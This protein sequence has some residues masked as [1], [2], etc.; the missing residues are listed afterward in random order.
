MP[1]HSTSMMVQES[2][3]FTC[4]FLKVGHAYRHTTFVTTYRRVQSPFETRE[5]R[6]PSFVLL[7][8]G[9]ETNIHTTNSSSSSHFQYTNQTTHQSP[10]LLSRNSYPPWPTWKWTSTY[11]ITSRK[12]KSR[13][14]R[15]GP[16][17]PLPCKL[18]PAPPP[19]APSKAGS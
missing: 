6:G 15:P 16:A 5:F 13:P 12:P 9:P 8:S 14:R 19:S 1:F 2:E 3:T 17:N 18:I 7:R 11:R 10:C 4:I